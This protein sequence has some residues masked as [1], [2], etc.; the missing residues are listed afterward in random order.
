MHA[1]FRLCVS[2]FVLSFVLIHPARPAELLVDSLA[3]DVT[4]DTRCT[5]REAVLA[6]NTDADGNGCV[7]SG[8]YG[9]DRISFAVSGLIYVLGQIEVIDDLTIDGQGTITLDAAQFGRLFVAGQTA[10]GGSGVTGVRFRLVGLT[11]QNGRDNGGTSIRGS[12]PFGPEVGGGCIR[13][14]GGQDALLE[15]QDSVVQDCEVVPPLDQF[16]GGGA[17]WMSGSILGAPRLVIRRSI[18]RENAAESGTG[19]AS[20]GAIFASPI[21]IGIEVEIEDSRITANRVESRDSAFGGGVTIGQASALSVIRSE[22]T[23]NEVRVDGR[24]TT[25]AVAR[26]GGLRLGLAGS[27]GEFV[28]TTIALNRVLMIG[29]GSAIARG[30][31][32]PPPNVAL[33][34]G[35]DAAFEDDEPF[36][37]GVAALRLNN[38]TL[39]DNRVDALDGALGE[40]GGIAS[41]GA[42]TVELANTI[43]SQN[44][45]GAQPENCRAADPLASLGYNLIDNNCGIAAGVG[46]LVGLLALLDD[47]AANGGAVDGMLSALPMSASPALDAGNPA[48]TDPTGTGGACLADDQRGESRPASAIHG[49]ICDIGAVELEAPFGTPG[50]TQSVPTLG[51]PGLLLLSLLLAVIAALQLPAIGRR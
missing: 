23:F 21:G 28:N 5:L 37:R 19:E 51:L 13:H 6:A 9:D 7:A 47:L 8:S 39:V 4:A 36:L 40:A 34:G 46:D 42:G 31:E 20:G 24:Q 10:R 22:F 48:P 33:A 45:V 15:I 32:P 50:G 41:E 26:G 43:L 30:G 38:V 16:A 1:A 3:D 49:P 11:L 44:L 35:V 17:I 25:G 14:R 18:L 27:S 12:N 29:D 2:A